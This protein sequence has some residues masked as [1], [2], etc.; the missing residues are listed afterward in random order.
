MASINW[1]ENIVPATHCHG[2]K[3]R[4]LFP[5]KRSLSRKLSS[6][7]VPARR[8]KMENYVVYM[9]SIRMSNV[10]PIAGGIAAVVSHIKD[11]IVVQLQATISQELQFTHV[12]YNSETLLIWLLCY[13]SSLLRRVSEA[14]ERNRGSL[15]RRGFLTFDIWDTYGRSSR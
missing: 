11:I 1:H 7:S 4:V 3:G 13:A 5:E 6:A 2:N 8:H 12:K 15:V 10:M 14:S 9:R